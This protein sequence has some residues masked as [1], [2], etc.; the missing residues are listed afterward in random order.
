MDIKRN[1]TEFS[2]NHYRLV[3]VL[4]VAITV[5]LGA[6]MPLIRVD[7]DP[8]NMLAEDEPVRLQHDQTKADFSLSDIVVLG[9]VNDQHPEGVFN[10]TSLTRIH[11]LTNYIKTWRSQKD[12][13]E[14][15][16]EVDLMALSVVDHISQG[17]PGEVSFEWLMPHPP[18][19]EQ[20]ALAIRDRAMSNP[21]LKGTLVSEDG[22]ALSV[23]IPLTSKHV[24]YEL[25]QD[26]SQRVADY[27]GDDHFH[28]T[29][30]PVAEDTF[31]VEMFVQMAISAP[32]AMLVIFM[33]MLLFFR[34]LVS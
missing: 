33:L 7:T 29:G 15:V 25:Y 9:V 24:S 34:K 32:L 12:P 16:I 1:V 28:V 20:E 27:E 17:G 23:F 6:F 13:N 8:E 5:V 3:T 26:L 30:L 18:A 19:S 4:M 22:K 14:G 21:L 31:G 2:L 10:K 11:E